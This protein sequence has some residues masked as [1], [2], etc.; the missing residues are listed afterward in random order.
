[1]S[2]SSRERG[3]MRPG[4]HRFQRLLAAL[5]LP[6][7]APGPVFLVTGTNGKGSVCAFLEAA[8]R[9]A[10]FRTG[11]YTSPH[12][13]NATER[14]RIQGSPIT[15][16]HFEDLC[17]KA[18]SAGQR[19]LGDVSEFET[20]TAAASLAFFE[21]KVGFSVVEI[22]LGGHLDST[23]A[24]APSVSILTS[25]GLD[26]REFLGETIAKIAADKAH[27]SRR[28]VPLVVGDLCPESL[29]SVS[30]TL[31]KTGGFLVSS[32][33]PPKQ[34]RE[35]L[36]RV[37]SNSR[38]WVRLN[39]RNL[40]TALTALFAYEETGDYSFDWQKIEEGLTKAFWPGRFDVREVSGRTVIFDGAHN[41]SGVEY[42]LEQYA[43]SEFSE[44]RPKII[45]AS[46]SDKDWPEILPRVAKLAS[47]IILT[48]V[49]SPRA[50]SVDTLV[51]SVGVGDVVASANA[52]QALEMAFQED[53]AVPVLVVG[54]LSLVGEAMEILGID[55]LAPCGEMGTKE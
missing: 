38:P 26:H 1:M 17:E 27:I 35:L 24:A 2:V 7:F 31:E 14:I 9:G 42:F 15:E 25:V 10:E 6:D 48:A 44:V 49:N 47:S 51:S 21:H 52:R 16:E 18:C 36:A 33:N 8:L 29:K 30:E 50:V 40:R 53:S 19:V 37:L 12:L 23:N 4:A 41:R 28:N 3:T 13:V 55:P 34:C 39:E 43:E 20:I 11:L 32:V 46:L 5:G 22:G 54:S 45:Y